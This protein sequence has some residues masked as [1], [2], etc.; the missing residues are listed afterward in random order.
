MLVSPQLFVSNACRFF[1]LSSQSSLLPRLSFI[2]SRNMATTKKIALVQTT[3]TSDFEK[4]L[5]NALT[6]VEEAADNG[7][8][9]VAFP[10]NFLFLGT[11]PEVVQEKSPL[12]D[13]NNHFIFQKFSEIASKRS[14]SILLGSVPERILSSSPSSSSSPPSSPRSKIFNTCFLIDRHGQIISR[15]RKIHLFDL[16]LPNVQLMESKGADPGTELVVIPLELTDPIPSTSTSPSPSPSTPSTLRV[17]LGLTICYDLRFP[18]QYQKLRELGAEVIAIPSAFTVPTGEAHWSTL[19]RSRA[20]ETQCYVWAPAQFGQHNE[21]RRTY[22]K[23]MSIDPWGVVQATAPDEA[24]II[25]SE[26]DPEVIERVRTQMPVFTHRVKG[27]D[28]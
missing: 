13:E 15:Y 26:I 24:C 7:A 16:S 20:I 11:T 1:A 19:L 22:G 28:F 21:K 17:N 8:S 10:E 6:Q 18:T 9:L 3:S 4:N 5:L 23:T 14:I 25:Y 2:S 27:I 12:V